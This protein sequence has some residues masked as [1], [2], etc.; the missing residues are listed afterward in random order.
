MV[1]PHVDFYNQILLSFK[2]VKILDH[3]TIQSVLETPGLSEETFA[4]LK[5]TMQCICINKNW[6]LHAIPVF[7][8]SYAVYPLSMS[9]AKNRQTHS[10]SLKKSQLF[11]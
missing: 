10:M 1:L 7:H 9:V 2:V 5:T 6:T 4:V 11:L 3:E 8:T